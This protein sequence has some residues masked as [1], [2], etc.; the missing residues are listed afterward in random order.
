MEST[1]SIKSEV[2]ESNPELE[3]V[4]AIISQS[5]SRP[6]TQPVANEGS[7]LED[8]SELQLTYLVSPDLNIEPSQPEIN[9][10]EETSTEK[11]ATTSGSDIYQNTAVVYKSF[12]QKAKELF[13]SLW[14]WFK[15]RL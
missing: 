14:S 12:T 5:S 13:K 6:G 10:I 15:S 8:P 4:I 2:I 9:T 11:I 7:N 3:K 1:G